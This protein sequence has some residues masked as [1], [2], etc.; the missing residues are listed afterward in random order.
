MYK[1]VVIKDIHIHIQ[2]HLHVV[3]MS[4]D[5]RIILDILGGTHAHDGGIQQRDIA[6]ATSSSEKTTRARNLQGTTQGALDKRIL[7]P[8]NNVKQI[9]A[10]NSRKA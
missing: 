9:P 5:K 10:P 8:V 4:S 1:A 3:S 6:K 7:W 2:S